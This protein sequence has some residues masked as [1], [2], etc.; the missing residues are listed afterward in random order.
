MGRFSR[1]KG[2]HGSGKKSEAPDLEAH[3]SD[4]AWYDILL[5]TADPSKNR[6]L[7]QVRSDHQP[8][9]RARARGRRGAAAPLLHITCRVHS[10][11]QC[12]HLPHI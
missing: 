11:Q 1:V 9:P 10:N 12:A 2:G 6:F 3:F 7:V 8:R 5:R 4:G